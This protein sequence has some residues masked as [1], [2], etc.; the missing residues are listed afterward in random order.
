MYKDQLSN[1]AT[2]LF[3]ELHQTYP[4]CSVITEHALPIIGSMLN[5]STYEEA[6]QTLQAETDKIENQRIRGNVLVRIFNA[7]MCK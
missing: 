7:L 5:T 4:H 6:L 2:E 1:L 3:S